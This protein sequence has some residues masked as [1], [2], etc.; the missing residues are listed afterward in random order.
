[1]MLPEGFLD[2]LDDTTPPD[3]SHVMALSGG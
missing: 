3:D 1:V 2:D